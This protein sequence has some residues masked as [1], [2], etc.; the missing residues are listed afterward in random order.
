MK[1]HLRI[2]SSDDARVIHDIYD[3]Y[4]THTVA[5]YNEF[6][7]SV[8]AR[9]QEITRLLKDYPFLVAEDEHGTFLGFAN[10][11]PSRPQSGYRYSVELTIYLHP[12]TP[13]HSGVGSL[14]YEALLDCLRKQGYRTAY[15]VI[16]S[17]NEESQ[18][19][20]RRFG[21]ETLTTFPNSAYKHGRWLSAVWMWKA[22]N[23]FDARPALPIPFETFRRTWQP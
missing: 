17:G 19:L 23:P 8:E 20:H 6:N 3:Y 13:R 12:D 1:A 2:A 18:A 11:E 21:F 22:L 16:D 10:A 4:I 9:A 14:L 15:A 5:T 7:Q